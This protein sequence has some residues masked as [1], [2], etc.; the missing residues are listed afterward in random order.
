[1]LQWL[2]LL[3]LHFANYCN[4]AQ[5]IR[6]NKN[7]HP[8]TAMFKKSAICKCNILCRTNTPRVFPVSSAEV[9]SGVAPSSRRY[10]RILQRRQSPPSPRLQ[11][12]PEP[13]LRLQWPANLAECQHC[14]PLF[15]PNPDGTPGPGNIRS[16]VRSIP[17][18]EDQ[19]WR[20]SL[21]SISH[22][23]PIFLR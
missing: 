22:C 9:R 23:R 17:Q 11:E 1:M 5:D 18:A 6:F 21:F 15:A 20:S 14:R 12:R 19:T 10:V 4:R 2:P 7:K 16:A 13:S 3:R 8:Q